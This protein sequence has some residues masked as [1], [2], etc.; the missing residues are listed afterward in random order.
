[1]EG[2]PD[3]VLALRLTGLP[4]R[5]VKRERNNSEAL[6]RSLGELNSRA[7][8][9]EDD[10]HSQPPQLL[11]F[12]V[13]QELEL[14]GL[15]E[16]RDNASGNRVIM[17]RPRLEEWLSRAAREVDINL[18]DPRYNLPGDPSRLHDE[19]NRD[20]RKL[21]RLIDSLLTAQSPRILKLRQLLTQ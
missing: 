9:D 6:K 17:L 18:G 7:M 5:E 4:G 1:M 20:L 13:F 14:F 16:Y 21:Q 8:I 11:R 12:Q 10:E 2:K 19:I 15:R 3:R